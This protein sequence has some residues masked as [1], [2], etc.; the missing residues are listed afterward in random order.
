VVDGIV[1]ANRSEWRG[2]P[3]RPGV[4][5]ASTN[6]VAADHVGARVMRFDPQGDYPNHPFLYRRNAISLAAEAGVGPNSP[7][8]IEIIGVSPEEVAVPFTVEKYEED[9]DRD[10]QIRDGA[11]CVATYLN[12]RDS[13]VRTHDGRYL[14]MRDGAVL[15]DGPDIHAMHAL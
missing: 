12:Q 1:A 8:R 14:A 7:D 10:G 9:S 15:W 11:A 4:I 5:L 13:F 2:T 6:I 3:M